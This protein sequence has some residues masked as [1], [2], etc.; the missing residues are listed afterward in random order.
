M[1]LDPYNKIFVPLQIIVTVKEKG[2]LPGEISRLQKLLVIDDLLRE[3]SE[4]RTEPS[5]AGLSCF[6]LN[7]AHDML[8]T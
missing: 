4:T 3:I 8:C 7:S 6:S 2:L 5:A 1:A